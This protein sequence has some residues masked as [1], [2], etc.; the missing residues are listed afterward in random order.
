MFLLLSQKKK[1]PEVLGILYILFSVK[2]DNSVK[3]LDF[4]P[5]LKTTWLLRI[6]H[7]KTQL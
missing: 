4:F 6:L 5:I 7:C 1:A 3:L 2:S